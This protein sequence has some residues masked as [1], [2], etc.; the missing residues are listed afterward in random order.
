MCEAPLCSD[1]R[2]VGTTVCP[3]RA[4]GGGGDV[5]EDTECLYWLPARS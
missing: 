5:L 1:G 4:V 3:V 2:Q